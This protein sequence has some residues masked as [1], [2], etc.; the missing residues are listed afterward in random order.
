ML[1][2]SAGAARPDPYNLPPSAD[3]RCREVPVKVRWQV[4]QQQATNL[5]YSVCP[6]RWFVAV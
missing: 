4:L 5:P 3:I 2:R 6:V 1:D